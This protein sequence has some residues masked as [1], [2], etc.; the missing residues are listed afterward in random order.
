MFKLILGSAMALLG[1]ALGLY[2]GIWWGFIGGIV[3]VIAAIRAP[4][5]VSMNVATG[6]AKIMFSGFLGW[7]SA[8]FLIIPGAAIVRAA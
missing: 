5:L 3:D 7:A 6:V 2:V 1:V 4:E 8:L